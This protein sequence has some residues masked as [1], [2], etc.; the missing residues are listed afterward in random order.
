MSLIKSWYTI[1][2]AV[3]KYGISTQQLLLWI[4][5]GL[6]RTEETKGQIMLVNADDIEQELRLTPSL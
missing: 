3:S 2:E 4:D 6:I 1:D 5:R